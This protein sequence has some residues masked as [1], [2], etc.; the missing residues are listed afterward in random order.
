MKFLKQQNLS[1]FN[2]SDNTIIANSY[3]RVVMDAQGG[4]ILPKGTT[5]QR[6]QTDN[7]HQ[8]TNAYGTIRYNT[9]TNDIEAYIFNEDTVNPG[10]V[11]ES[12]KSASRN[13]ITKQ[14]L[15]PGDGTETV[16]GPLAETPTSANN[17]IVL[18][19]NVMQ[20]SETNYDIVYSDGVDGT[21]G[22]NAPY[23]AGWYIKFTAPI[24]AVSVTSTDTI[25]ITIFYGYSN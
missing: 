25:Y 3:G 15:G 14:T 2:P 24:P 20:I 23:A 13:A 10:G 16:F 22:P 19:E 17:I 12:V 11:W 21:L 5:S 7:V 9:E 8:P 4:L 1:R 18:L 6:P